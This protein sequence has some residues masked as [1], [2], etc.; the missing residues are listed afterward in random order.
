MFDLIIVGAGIVGG[1]CA[2]ACARAGLKVLVVDRGP[3]GGGTTGAGMGHIVVMDDSEAQFALTAFSRDLWQQ[4]VPQLPADVEYDPCGTLWLAAD[5]EE[6]TEVRRK[7]QAYTEH[8]VRV[9]VLDEE[10]IYEAEPNLRPGLAGGLRVPEDAVL[11]PPC[12]ARFL[13]KQATRDGAEVRTGV[14]VIKM[15]PEGGVQLADGSRISAGRSVNATGPWSPTLAPGLP[16]RKRKGHLVITDRQPGFIHN[17]IVELGY[18]KSAHGASKDSVAFNVQPRKTGQVLIGSSRQ[19][20]AEETDVDQGIL[21]RMLN[22]ALEYM[23]ALGRLSCTRV[24]TGHRAATPDKLPLIGPSVANDRIWLA[25]GHEGL[26]ITT[27]LG[28]A[29]LL[30]DLLLEWP[31][32]IPAAPYAPARFPNGD[33]N[34]D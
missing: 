1:A 34:H 12:A 17:Q 22:R 26:G 15:L 16:V 11:Y 25:T 30:A 10:D 33:G 14:T 27:S 29:S 7:Q 4:L 21:E 31:A 32:R 19:F 3:I 23:P 18:L 24:W 20:D 5:E 28:T 8:G 13:L 2:A 6:M 9:E